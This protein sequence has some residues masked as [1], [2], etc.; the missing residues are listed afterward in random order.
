MELT[1]ALADNRRAVQSVGQVAAN[2]A[3]RTK[4]QG[5]GRMFHW[6]N[7]TDADVSG[8]GLDFTP[9]GREPWLL[10]ARAP[11][12]AEVELHLEEPG[13]GEVTAPGVKIEEAAITVIA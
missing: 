10:V 12:W 5:P 11:G 13:G 4:A 7:W 6:L 8:A 9:N 2:L 1:T 3:S